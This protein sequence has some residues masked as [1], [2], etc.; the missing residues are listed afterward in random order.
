MVCSLLSLEDTDELTGSLISLEDDIDE[1]LDSLFSLI[2]LDTTS[3]SL[4]ELDDISGSLLLITAELLDLVF[5]E[6]APTVKA[7]IIKALIISLFFIRITSL[8]RNHFNAFITFFPS[9]QRT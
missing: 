8:L 6:H 1:L 4:L 2:E 7:K 5:L 3:D 9:L